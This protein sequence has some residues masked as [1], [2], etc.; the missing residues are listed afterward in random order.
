[1]SDLAK[2]EP[3]TILDDITL[4]DN[5]E[6]SKLRSQTIKENLEEAE[7]VE[8]VINKTRNFYRV[9][10][11]R[12]AILYFAITDMAGINQMYQNSLQYVKIL[13]DEAISSAKKVKSSDDEAH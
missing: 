4:I 7:E 9:V 10:A 5:L 11:E 8:V 2:A 12:G 13:F 6:V 3:D 1:L